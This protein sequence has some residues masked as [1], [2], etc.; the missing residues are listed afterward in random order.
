MRRDVRDMLSL[1]LHQGITHLSWFPPSCAH[2]G[3]TCLTFAPLKV[4]EIS[5]HLVFNHGFLWAHHF[6]QSEFWPPLGLWGVFASPASCR[7]HLWESPLAC[8]GPSFRPSSS[9]FDVVLEAAFS[10]ELMFSSCH[11]LENEEQVSFVLGPNASWGFFPVFLWGAGCWVH[12]RES[13]TLSC[14]HF[15][16]IL[17]Y[18]LVSSCTFEWNFLFHE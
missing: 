3:Y 11:I 5:Q 6:V 14:S 2:I 9:L 15:L 1:V 16:L 10:E 8:L 7:R 12:L 13:L 17:S 18:Q 4:L